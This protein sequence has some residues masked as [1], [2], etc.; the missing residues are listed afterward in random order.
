M[1]TNKI[2]NA[3]ILDIV[4][5]GRNKEYGAYQLRKTYNRRL[6]YSLAVMF[7]VALVAVAGTVLG[8]TGDPNKM[9]LIVQ[10]E[11]SLASVIDK[12]AP[13]PPPPPPPPKEIKIKQ[14]EFTPPKIVKEQVA[15]PPPKMDDLDEVKIGA[16]T[17]DG[18]KGDIVAPPVEVSVGGVKPPV[19]EADYTGVFETVQIQAQF[20]GGPDAWQKYLSRNLQ[21]D[22]PTENGATP[23]KYAVV[24]S[25]IVDREG[26]IS[27]VKAETDPG[28]GTAD[29]AVRVIKRGPKW[30]PAIQNG[31]SVIYRQKQTIVFQ[32]TES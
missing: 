1:E 31:R 28:F 14:I 20:P 25:F 5:D 15:V 8:K 26:N 12:P 29:E 21:V 24:V 2:L 16:K 23:G 30:T 18:V 17:I 3:D 6:S 22:V 7:G 32:V 19:K 4:F 9:P 13:P 10:G 11:V 27:E